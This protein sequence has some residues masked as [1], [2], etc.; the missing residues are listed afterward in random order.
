MSPTQL[1]DVLHGEGARI[2]PG[3]AE[4]IAHYGSEGEPQMSPP[5]SV[6][7]APSPRASESLCASDLG[8]VV[9]GEQAL[10]AS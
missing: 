1:S 8:H 2:T 5:L 7:G 9:V 3:L 6:P 4:A 10:L